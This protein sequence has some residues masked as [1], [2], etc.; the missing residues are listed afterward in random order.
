MKI[1]INLA[2]E[3]FRRDRPILIG[4]AAVALLMMVSLGALVWLA[5]MARC[6]GAAAGE[7]GGAGAERSNQ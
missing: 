5:L 3:P 1:G 7:R 2:S 6:R 4:S